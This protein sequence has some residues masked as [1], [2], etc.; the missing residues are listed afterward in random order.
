MFSDADY[1]LLSRFFLADL[2]A[3]A[4]LMLPPDFSFATAAF[5]LR[6]Y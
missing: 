2:Y 1:F 6:H 3:D 5:A 4:M